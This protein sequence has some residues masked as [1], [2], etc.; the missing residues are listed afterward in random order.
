MELDDADIGLGD[1][2]VHLPGREVR[3]ERVLPTLQRPAQG[4][5]L[6]DRAGVQYIDDDLGDPLPLG[7]VLLVVGGAPLRGA[8]PRDEHFVV[9]GISLDHSTELGTLL[10]GEV[11]GPGT[12]D[13]LNP[14][15]R[16]TIATTMTQR[17]R[18]LR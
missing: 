16:A 2:V 4:R 3:E 15:K 11:L 14:I 13:G 7:G 12:Q 10:I 8:L 5:D 18:L 1:A 9:C 17:C 6:G